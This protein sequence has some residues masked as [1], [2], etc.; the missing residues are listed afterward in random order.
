VVFWLLI[1]PVLGSC[2]V[3]FARYIWF[4]YSPRRIGLLMLEIGY[5]AYF[6]LLQSYCL[7]VGYCVM[8]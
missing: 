4:M 7:G 6:S 5:L 1:C 3:L 2:C 8:Y